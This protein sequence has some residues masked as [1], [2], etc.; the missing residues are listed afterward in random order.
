MPKQILF[1]PFSGLLVILLLFVAYIPAAFSSQAMQAASPFVIHKE[2]NKYGLVNE[3]GKQVLPARYDS[4]QYT[5][6]NEYF[7][8][9]L[10]TNGKKQQAGLINAKGKELIPIRYTEIKPLSVSRYAVTDTEK[11]IAVFDDAGIA[12]TAFQ[13]DEITAF[14]GKLARFYQQGKA[15]IVDTD[16]RIRLKP[17][18]QDIIIHND[19]AVDVVP[20]RKWTIT[21]GNN[22]QQ[23]TLLYD[24]IRPLGEDR[25]AVTTRFY[26]S[27]GRSTTMTALSDASGNILVSYKPMHIDLFK[28]GVARVKEGAHFGLIDLKGNYV[29]PAEWDSLAVVQ[30]VVVAGMRLTANW[31]WHLFNLQGKK[32]SRHTYQR[33]VPVAAGPLP[34][35]KDNRWGYIDQNGSETLICRYD[36][37]F[38]FTGE[39][40]RVRYNGQEGVINKEGLWQIR[41]MAE[42]ITILSPS[43]FLARLKGGYQLLNETGEVLFETAEVLKPIVGG[44]VEITADRRW[45]LIDLN[46][47]RL[48][49]PIYDWISDLQE[50]LAFIATLEGRKGILSPDG[51]QY[52][53]AGPTTWEQLYS[54]H[55]GFIGAHIGRQQGFVDTNGKLRIANRY[56]TVAFFSDGMAAVSIRGKWG[57]VDKIERLRVQPLYDLVLPYQNGNAVVQLSS[58]QGI[59]DKKGQLVLPLE[60]DKITRLTNG[61]FLLKQGNLIGLADAQ[62][63]R[64]ISPKY[65]AVQDLQNG[66]LLVSRNGK[67]GLVTVDGVGTIPM[68]YDVLI[69]DAEN[70]Q[71]LCT[72]QREGIQRVTLQ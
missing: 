68:V 64:I 67:K 65:D 1:A 14:R 20:V 72:H 25:W 48:S 69:H 24:S 10:R 47:R 5:P 28:N 42:N 26:D 16:G 51:K 36:T 3:R 43:R 70:N 63:N 53:A 39:L 30:S 38:A 17:E 13:F 22:K 49:F 71:Y 58:R 55:E 18:Y 8:A 7:I 33:I 54:M 27:V 45:G 37:T 41:P 11:K 56:D 34:A 40:A 59:I 52:I 60:Y 12:K 19:Q 32:L 9:Y 44:I 66:Y 21:D 23:N 61:R 35:K 6:H 29:L 4:L 46:G 57:Y 2:G 15:G 62:G 31:Y 50:G